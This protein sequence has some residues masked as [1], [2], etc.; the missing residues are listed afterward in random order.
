MQLKPL[1]LLPL[2]ATS[3]FAKCNKDNGNRTSTGRPSKQSSTV[4]L[5]STDEFAFP[6]S[7]PGPLDPP[8][9]EEKVQTTEVVV[10]PTTS[11]AAQPSSEVAEKTSIVAPVAESPVV[12]T[13]EAETIPA[14]D[15][16][17]KTPPVEFLSAVAPAPASGGQQGPPAPAK[18]YCGTPN[19]SEVLF[20]TPWIVFSMNYN[21]QSIKGSSCTG[22]YETSGSGNGQRIH[23]S[24]DFKI[25]S[26]FDPNIVK[27]YSFVGLTQGLETRLTDIKSIPSTFDWKIYEESEWKG[28]VVYDFMT[29]DTKGDSTSSNAQELMLW[30]YWHGGQV[31]IGWAEGPIATVNNLFGKD[32]W[33][34][35]QGVNLD[36]GITVT[37][38]LAPENNMFGNASAG[39][40]DGDI[41][42]WL[43]ALS[44]NGVFTADTYVNVGNAGN[45]PYWGNVFFENNLGL[46][47]N[48]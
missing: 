20:N 5:Q 41:K 34:L 37:S 4:L 46:R 32:G 14:E 33:K 7:A 27:G 21:Q 31:P 44:K 9:A 13:P 38:L 43:V 40:F 19:K 42:D 45:E 23:W 25:D 17:A 6:S 47:I 12:K 2:L 36:T 28:N 29:S 1:V 48:L 24:S 10:T 15:P 3:A 8:Q 35:Y 16:V 11:A 30:L 39:A 22:L 26:N 18:T